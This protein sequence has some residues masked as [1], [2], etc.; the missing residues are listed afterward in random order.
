M[1][2]FKNGI[3]YDLIGNPDA[4]ENLV[5]VHGSGCN[6]KFLRALAKK[7]PEFN[8]YLP[9]LPD[10]GK[11]NFLDCKNAESYVDAITGFVSDMDNVTIIGHSLGGTICL[12]VAAKNLPSVK[13]CV[14]I[15]SGAKFDKMD[16]RIHNMVKRQ[17][18]DWEYLI[19]SLGSFTC[20]AVLLDFLNFEP[21]EIILKDFAIDLKLDLEYTLKDIHIPT[22]ITV[23]KDDY[24]TPPEYSEKIRKGV[25]NSRLVYFKGCRHMLPIAKR[26]EVA[27]LIRG[28]VNS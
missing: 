13:R 4:V 21:P 10:H 9:D 1:T 5:F 23:G 2:N 7:L 3:Y 26:K 14:A 6:R 12:G 28:F 8:C 16:V 22:L 27:G 19:K 24:L 11:S 17:K 20:P 25:K 15:S 18:V